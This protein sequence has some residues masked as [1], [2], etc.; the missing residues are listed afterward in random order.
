MKF[1]LGENTPRYW[2]SNSAYITSFY[3]VLS[4]LFP[5]GEKFFI[6]SV[7]AYDADVRDPLLRSQMRT[8]AQQEAHHSLQHRLLNG[9][10]ANS[11]L[12]SIGEQIEA[13]QRKLYG[14]TRRNVPKLS[15]LAL[16]VVDEHFTATFARQFLSNE[17]VF[18]G[19]HSSALP[20]WI[21]HGLE[22]TEHK[23]VAFDV[24]RSVGGGYT[25]R[26]VIM[27]SRLLLAPLGLA[28][29]QLLI[30]GRDGKLFDVKDFLQF[31]RYMFGR[32]G[33]VRGMWPDIRAFF[34]RDFHPWQFDDRELIE[35]WR[36]KLEPFI[37]ESER[38]MG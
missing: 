27:A 12:K 2:H 13:R 31:M 5:E 33:V 22:E 34:R 17:A 3:T 10:L 35:A 19:M 7:R 36:E 11:Q 32:N 29:G 38:R 9:L 25:R 24:Y 23:A 8:F 28:L 21:W 6:E 37:V 26:V 20:L 16:T 4:L 30:L 14:R 15:Q 18:A 1:D